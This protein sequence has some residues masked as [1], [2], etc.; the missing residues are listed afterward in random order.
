[1][2]VIKKGKK[3]SSE[4]QKRKERKERNLEPTIIELNVQKFSSGLTFWRIPFSGTMFYFI[5]KVSVCVTFPLNKSLEA[6]GGGAC[7]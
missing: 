7:L 3:Y 5:W 6:G 2:F 4:I 1:M